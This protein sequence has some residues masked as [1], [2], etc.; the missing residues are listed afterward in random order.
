MALNRLSDRDHTVLG[1]K[2][3]FLFGEPYQAKTETFDVVLQQ[4]SN[5]VDCLISWSD[6]FLHHN[7]YH[8]P[9]SASHVSAFDSIAK[10]ATGIKRSTLTL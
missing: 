9:S 1:Q 5:P 4:Y 3:G 7:G 10:P 8:I 2:F 6:G